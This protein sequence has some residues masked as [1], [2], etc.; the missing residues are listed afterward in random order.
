MAQRTRQCNAII[1]EASFHMRELLDGFKAFSK[2]YIDGFSDLKKARLIESQCVGAAKVLLPIC[3]FR[4]GIISDL[5][6]RIEF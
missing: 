2:L 3:L 5:Q 4:Q 1:M 6:G